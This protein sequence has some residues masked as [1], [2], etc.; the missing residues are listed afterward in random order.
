LFQIFEDCKAWRVRFD[1]GSR[2]DELRKYRGDGSDRVARA[3]DVDNVLSTTYRPEKRLPFIFIALAT[4]V[5][6]LMASTMM[7]EGKSDELSMVGWG[8]N[9]E[10]P[11][12]EFRKANW[13]T[14]GLNI[15]PAG[16]YC[17]TR[18]L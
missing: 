10:P 16:G 4:V 11:T 7:A 17:R 18:Y 2:R 1:I 14:D 6:L 9:A 13:Y 8:S 12:E 15:E 3:S 5:I